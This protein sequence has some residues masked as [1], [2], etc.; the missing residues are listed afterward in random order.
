M[1][2]Q[3]RSLPDLPIGFGA[4][5]QNLP[6]DL[7]KACQPSHIPVAN[8][9]LPAGDRGL[10]DVI[11][12]HSQ[13]RRYAPQS[14]AASRRAGDAPVCHTQAGGAYDLIQTWKRIQMHQPARFWFILPASQMHSNWGFCARL[15]SVWLS[16]RAVESTTTPA[17]QSNLSSSAGSHVSPPQPGYD[18]LFR[19]QNSRPIFLVFPFLYHIIR[20]IETRGR[21][22]RVL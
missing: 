11:H 6:E 22:A 9:H 3:F 13:L 12:Y 14:Q 4:H 7:R 21:H 8:L 2:F 19:F 16:S 20:K 1:R 5:S 15:S 10:A 18:V 17:T